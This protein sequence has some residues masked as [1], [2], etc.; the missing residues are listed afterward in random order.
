MVKNEDTQAIVTAIQ[1]RGWQGIAR[2]VLDVIE[3][4]APFVSQLLWIAQPA[5]RIIGAHHTIHALASLL[6][7]PD[8][9]AHL[10]DQLAPLPDQDADE[11]ASA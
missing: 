10:Q 5:G 1:A 11:I 6:E 7:T 2:T 3:P 4:V 9:I 8:G